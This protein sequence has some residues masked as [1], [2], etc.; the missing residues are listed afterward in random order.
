[1]G[2]SEQHIHRLQ[3]LREAAFHVGLSGRQR[4]CL[5]VTEEERSS[6]RESLPSEDRAKPGLDPHLRSLTLAGCVEDPLLPRLEP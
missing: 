3:D 2:S 5:P 4:G 6:W 1:M